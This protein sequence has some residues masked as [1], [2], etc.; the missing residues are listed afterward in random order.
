M[1]KNY[2]WNIVAGV[3]LIMVAIAGCASS[4]TIKDPRDGERT[5]SVAKIYGTPWEAR[6][7]AAT[8]AY[9]QGR[10]ADAENSLQAALM[11]AEQHGKEDL[12]LTMTLTKMGDLAATLNNLASIHR[13]QGSYGKAESFYKRSLAIWE[14]VLGPEHPHVA[15]TLEKYAPC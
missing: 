14:R 2:S 10:Y 6:M 15:A 4:E 13:K 11:E 12:R 5:E 9:G 3:Y 1:K 7:A 8:T